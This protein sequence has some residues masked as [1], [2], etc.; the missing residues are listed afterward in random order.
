MTSVGIAIIV[1][2][3]FVYVLSG[4]KKERDTYDEIPSSVLI[5]QLSK[6]RAENF[7]KARITMHT[8]SN[9]PPCKLWIS[10]EKSKW[11]N[12]G[13]EIDVQDETGN[14]MTPWFSV[15]DTDGT[16]FEVVGYMTGET[17]K[18]AKEGAK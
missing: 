15:Q 6:F 12:V 13:W 11:E 4:H 2:S 17:F 16:K 9:C 8:R 1:I 10:Q 3:A 5:E 18:K 7:S 14:R